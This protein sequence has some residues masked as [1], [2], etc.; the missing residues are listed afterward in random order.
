M[1][2]KKINTINTLLKKIWRYEPNILKLIF[3]FLFIPLYGYKNKDK[4]IKYRYIEALPKPGTTYI[5]RKAFADCI[6]L[7][8]VIISKSV[9][10]IGE[11]AFDA[12]TSLQSVIIMNSVKIICND[13]FADCDS[14]KYVYI[15]DSIK[16]ISNSAFEDC[17]ML[18][19]VLIPKHLEKSLKKL[20][21]FPKYTRII[22]K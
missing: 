7:Q 13:A 2:N 16:T 1:S 17:K 9:V 12:C 4:S 18:K 11:W 5:D 19:S 8:S 15:G 14:L 10:K 22:I 3:K 21:V 6:H 20:E